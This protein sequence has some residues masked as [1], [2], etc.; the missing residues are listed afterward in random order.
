MKK[1]FLTN[2]EKLGLI[3]ITILII[4]SQSNIAKAKHYYNIEIVEAYCTSSQKI[5]IGYSNNLE[6]T[7]DDN[8]VLENL[9]EMVG[10]RYLL[11]I[12]N[13]GNNDIYDDELINV[14]PIK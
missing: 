13:K 4:T 1:L 10:N 9:E 14:Y 2:M 8:Y 3:L 7:K 12:D 11:I 5:D 6:I